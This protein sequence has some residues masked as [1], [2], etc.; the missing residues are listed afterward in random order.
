ML[1]LRT[2]VGIIWMSSEMLVYL[3]QLMESMSLRDENI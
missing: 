1:E 2:P 3:L